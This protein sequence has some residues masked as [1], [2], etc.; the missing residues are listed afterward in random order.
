MKCPQ[1]KSDIGD[2]SKFCKQCGTNISSLE[3]ASPS[4]TQTMETPVADLTP[5]TLFAGRYEIIEELGRGGM[6]KVYRVRD[7]KLNEEMALKV[8]K[9]EIAT[10]KEIIARFKNELK[11]ARKI[12]HKHVCK[13][14]DLNEEGDTA[15]ITMEYVPG[16]DLKSYIKK[17]ESLT[18]KEAISIAQQICEGIAGA[19][20]IG[21]IH[22]DLKPQNIMIDDT[23]NAKI[24][25]FGI[26]RS[27]EA[28]GVTGTGVMIGTPEY[29]SPE[30]ADG[31]EADQRSDLYSLGVISMR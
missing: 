13:M 25:D 17:Q 30:Q 23:G 24:M 22:R 26:A 18:E 10:S 3:E 16:E 27:V 28:A 19:H 4:F 21:V 11:L 29:I 14:Y 31:E 12:A 20:E 2:D 1:C 9:P 15:Y 6:G 7:D 5:G 8:I